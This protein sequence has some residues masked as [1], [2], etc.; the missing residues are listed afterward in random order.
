MNKIVIIIN[1]QHNI[2]PDDISITGVLGDQ[3]TDGC[4]T[5]DLNSH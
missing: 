2:V 1:A 5:I 4:Q 3:T